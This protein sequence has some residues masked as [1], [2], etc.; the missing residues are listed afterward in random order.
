MTAAPLFRLATRGPAPKHEFGAP[1]S[2]PPNPEL[3]RDQQTERICA[4]CGVV[5][6]TFHPQE[7]GGGRLWRHGQDDLTQVADDPGCVSDEVVMAA[8]ARAK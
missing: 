8:K 2:I 3:D 7:G 4:R 5:K 1:V 6:V